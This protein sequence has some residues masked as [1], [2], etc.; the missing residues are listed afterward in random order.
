LKPS[1]A[2]KIFPQDQP[3][4]AFLA[5][6]ILGGA[7][8]YLMTMTEPKALKKWTRN[9]THLKNKAAT[10]TTTRQSKKVFFFFSNYH[11]NNKREREQNYTNRIASRIPLLF[12]F[13]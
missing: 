5:A 8:V 10:T 13:F 6:F 12:F 4:V 3:W 11:N 9:Q 1:A 7:S 2:F